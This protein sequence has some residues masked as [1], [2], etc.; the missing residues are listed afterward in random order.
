MCPP[1]AAMSAACLRG[2]SQVKRYTSSVV[3]AAFALALSFS[4]TA[5]DANQGKPVPTA[6]PAAAEP[7]EIIVTGS[8]IKRTDLIANSPV[9]IV[10]DEELTLTATVNV[11]DVIRTLPQAVPGISPGV[12]NGNP[13]VAT[14]NLRG[15]DDERTLVLIDG[16]RF[17]GYDSEGIVDLNNIP[18]PLIERIDVVTG[19]A[20]AVYGSDAIAGVVN[21][22]L[23]DDFEGVQV[24]YDYA[25]ALHNSETTDNI[26]VT[27][28]SN[29]DGEK[30]NAAIYVG[31]TQRD[32]VSQADRAFSKNAIDTAS[33]GPFG[34]STDTQGAVDT[35]LD[36]RLGFQQCNPG[37]PTTCDLLPRG[38]R[39]FNFNKYNL[40]QVPEQRYQATALVHYDLADWATVYGRATFAQTQV[41]SVIAPSGTFFSEFA[42][43]YDSIFLSNQARGLLYPAAGSGLFQ[44]DVFGTRRC[45]NNPNQ[46]GN[47]DSLDTNCNGSLGVGDSAKYPVG[48]RTVEVGNRITRN[49]T[50]AY[51][52]V[53]GLKGDLPIFEGWNYDFSVQHART[54]LSR[55][56]ENDLKKSRVQDVLDASSLSLNPTAVDGGPCL[57]S[58]PTN[59]VLGNLFGD[60][61]LNS[62]SAHY[63]AL[64]INEEVYTTQDVIMLS[65]DGN[66]GE[67]VKIPGAGPIGLALGGEWRRTESDSFPDDCYSTPDC[68]LGFGSTTSVRAQQTVKEIFGEILVPLVEDKPFVNS[69]SF[70][71]GY[72][73][74][75]YTRVGGVSAYKVGGE[76]SPFEDFRL[77]IL[78]QNAVRAPNIFETSQPLTPSLD[79]SVGDPC[80]GFSENNGGVALPL[81]Q[82][83]RDLCIATG[84]PAGLFT[85]TAPGSGIWNTRVSDVIAGQINILQSGN[86][87]LKEETSRTLTIGGVY[88]PSALEGLTVTIDWYKVK[89]DD[90]ITNFTADDILP[91]CYNQALN[92]TG[93]PAQLLCSF[94]KRNPNTGALVGNPNYG[95]LQPEFNIATLEVDGVDF[96]VDYSLD[97]GSFGRVD[98]TLLGNKLIKHNDRPASITPMNVCKG[99]YG[100]V[101]LSPNT[102]VTF[103]QR[104]TWYFND[105]YLGYRWRFINATRFEDPS[106]ID[107]GVKTGQIPSYHYLDLAF[108]WE[109]TDI[110]AL[111]GFRFQVALDNVF[112]KDPP[113]VGQD[114]GPTDQ[115]SGNT[116]PGSFDSVGRVLKV[117]VTKN[118]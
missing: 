108:G 116:F 96:S 106:Q 18:T 13:G 40:L 24:D 6:T 14:V 37:N 58:A 64:Q 4:A 100:P 93:D 12:N 110:S 78:Y 85:E 25:N 82:Y 31:W 94:V 16:K 38:S 1:N 86:K 15:L 67:T 68:S 84:A 32:P 29:F 66:L 70:E 92:P 115:N 33:G 109:P 21:F 35:P 56:F 11:E 113:I 42:I 60:G 103:Q 79:N 90:A 10:S 2:T 55:I 117:S 83:T 99:L 73:Y 59:C 74:A 87:N 72:R 104:T 112:D 20:S 17:V 41:D 76:Y 5:Q 39:R 91:N 89:I 69:L 28:G 26:G 53:G 46:L 111:T 47:F 71:A 54:E 118:F 50:Q 97:V 49:R 44:E 23:K 81:D 22:I 88:Q 3:L 30:G 65:F 9:S 98:F 52:I 80:S 95:L 19:G 101:C 57:P 48:R 107:P 102:S 43:P 8:R 62:D 36:G 7:E 75:D 27:I 34:S 105:I 114:A 77:R 51:Q 45:L 63:M 61:N